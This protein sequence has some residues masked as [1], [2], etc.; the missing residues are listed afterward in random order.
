MDLGSTRPLKEKSTRKISGEGGWLR[1]KV[2]RVDNLTNFTCQM[3]GNL[4]DSDSWN[5]IRYAIGQ[6][7]DGCTFSFVKNCAYA[8]VSKYNI[9]HYVN[10]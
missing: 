4:G 1:C 7:R 3:S 9:T 10:I 6:C 2:H 5:N 8:T